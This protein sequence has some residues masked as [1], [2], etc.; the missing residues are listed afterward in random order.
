[1]PQDDWDF[2]Q[3][4]KNTLTPDIKESGQVETAKDMKRLTSIIENLWSQ[5]GFW[6]K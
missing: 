6:E 3:F 2:V 5:F 1:M 4:I